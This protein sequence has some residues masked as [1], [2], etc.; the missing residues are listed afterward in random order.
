LGS[1]AVKPAATTTYTL[2]ATNQAGESK[3]TCRVE[4]DKQL[5]VESQTIEQPA[6]P[7]EIIEPPVISSQVSE[8]PVV[9]SDN[10]EPKVESNEVVEPAVIV[11]EADERPTC[12]SF[13][14][15]RPLIMPGQ[16]ST[17]S[18]QVSN[19]ESIRIEPDIG[20]VSSLGS[21]AVKPA[22]TTIYTLIAANKAGESR[23]T[24]RVEI[25][26]RITIFSADSIHP[27]AL[28]EEFK[29]SDD[30]K[31]LPG[32][33]PPVSDPNSKLGRFLGYRSRKDESGKFIFI[34]VYEKKQEK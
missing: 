28:L 5:A 11:S 10:S 4:V 12:H 23:V 8:P 14:T 16:T 20:R 19:A 9:S 22:T 29:A 21:R 7:A 1:R 34:P 13:D 25:S 6:V 33:K 2:I 26:K 30:G 15:T 31:V 3:I 17:L 24:C 32:Q 18:W 27:Q